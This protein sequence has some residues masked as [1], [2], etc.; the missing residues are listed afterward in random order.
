[1]PYLLLSRVIIRVDRLLE[2]HQ[3]IKLAVQV[4]KAF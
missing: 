1:M 4:G 3:V 2:M